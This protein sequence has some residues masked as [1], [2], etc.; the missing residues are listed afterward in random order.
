MIEINA[1]RHNQSR[2]P[3]AELEKYNGQ[4][5][6]WSDDGTHILVAHADRAQ[7]EAMLVAMGIYPGDVL[8]CRVAVTDEV[9]WWSTTEDSAQS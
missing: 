9:A 3:R 4:F 5:V 7:M 6:A 2:F 8:I 1:F